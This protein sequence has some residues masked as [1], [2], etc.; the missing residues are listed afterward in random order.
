[1]LAAVRNGPQPEGIR[2]RLSSLDT[3]HALQASA[4]LSAALASFL[5]L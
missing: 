4:A 2:V 5:V 3:N 1:V